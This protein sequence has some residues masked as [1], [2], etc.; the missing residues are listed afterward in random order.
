MIKLVNLILI[1]TLTVSAQSYKVVDT[2]QTI[3]Y[4][5]QDEIA[6]PAMGTAFYGQDASID[7][8]QPDY[9]D[10]G[11]GTVTDN[12]TGLMWQQS[13]DINGD[14]VA[15]I[16]D[17]MSQTEALAGADTFSLAGY[18][19]WRLP[20][21]KE[22]YSLF[23]FSGEDPSGYSGTDTE[24]LIPFVNTDFFDVAY[25]DVDAGERIIDGQYASSTVYVST[26]MNGDATMFGVNF[27]DGRIKGYPMGPMPGQTEDKQF[28]VLYVR[29]N[30]AYGVND[31]VENGDSTVSDLATGL[32]WMQDDS[33]VGMNWEAALAYAQT[34]NAEIHLGYDDWRVPNSKELQSILDY[35]RSPA[36]TNSAAID[37]VF[38]STSI[39]DEGGENDYPFYWSSST[40]VNM[41]NGA[42]GAYVCF[43]EALGFMA[44]PFPPF[45]VTLLDVHGAGSQRSD[46]KTGDADDYPQGHGPQGDVVRIDNFVRL[47]RDIQSSTGLNDDPEA[48]SPKSFSLK[49]NYPN[50]FNPSTT[51]EY[52]LPVGA[53]VEI[54][55]Y[56]MLGEKV[57]TLVNEYQEAGTHSQV[58][59]PT[60]LSSGSYFYVF[61]SDGYREVGRM[62]LL[63]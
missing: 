27:V 3:F 48:Q 53:Q 13:T 15:N 61:D 34:K 59:N 14:G 55:V 8:H 47:V 11:D 41:N 5:N 51:L 17:K 56:N 44:A 39:I 2:G 32:M 6:A 1:S 22:A 42:W 25:G 50:P 63:K 28:Y 45:D 26:T 60:E 46:P 16:A 62:L 58:F 21:I 24:N 29:G 19:D 7:G 31:F 57:A 40:H 18:S 10:N 38:F 35:T 49:Q 9:T 30:E 33:Q 20:T 36:T 12:V 52:S 37:P 43:G 54:R 4:N 23:M